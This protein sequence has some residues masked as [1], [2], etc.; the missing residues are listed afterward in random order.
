M[1][2]IY[3]IA[4]TYRSG[5]M[6][7]VL[8]DKANWLAEHGHDVLIVT[9]DQRGR[10]PF[11]ALAEGVR[12]ID[13]GI[14]YETNNGGSFLNKLVRYP[15]KQLRHKRALRTLLLREKAD[16]VVSMFCGE[17]GLLPSIKDGSKKVLEIHFSR[18]KRI[19][20]GRKG[21]W[22]LADKFRSWQDVRIA[23][24]YDKFVVLTEEDRKLWGEL[25][26]IC[27]IP[28]ASPFEGVEPSS[29][30]ERRV[31]S[32]GR[33][34]YQKGYDRLI[35]AWSIVHAQAPDWVLDIYG[36]GELQGELQAQIDR[37]GLADSVHLL[38]P[39]SDIASAYQSA[40]VLAL[41]SH[42]EGLPMV[43]LEAQSFGLPLISF[44]CQCGPRDV[45][46]DG[47]NG[48]LVAEGDVPAL[49]DR[50][51]AVISDPALLRR[52]SDAS[53]ANSSAFT[54]A[55]IMSRWDFLFRSL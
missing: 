7:R 15:F 41:S 42:Y 49:A 21:I 24:K 44:A 4:G 47:Q 17:A 31:I 39:T 46:T 6:E 43:L 29:L 32:V 50:L 16:V 54:P 20:Y 25:P 3:N 10:E 13:L 5:G 14:D 12:C 55:A 19:Q 28:N 8:A 40:S 35:D 34:C 22:A 23:R 53:L 36:G 48:F 9:T 11:F 30:T 45:I 51:I 52:M 27:V 33:L 38:P 37:L 2:I 26:N 1:K 18:M